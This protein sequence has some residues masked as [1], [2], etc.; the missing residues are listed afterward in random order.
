MEQPMPSLASSDISGEV[1]ANV[2]GPDGPVGNAE[3]IVEAAGEQPSDDIE[4]PPPP[5]P[6]VPQFSAAEAP[7][8]VDAPTIDSLKVTWPNVVQTG[9]SGV[10]PEDTHFPEC[11]I[12]YALELSEVPPPLLLPLPATKQAPPLMQT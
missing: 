4:I 10:V 3:E 5:P 6:P 1:S 2:P 12:D 9:L 8:L 11:D 7:K